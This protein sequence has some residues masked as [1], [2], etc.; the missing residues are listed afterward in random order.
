MSAAKK[1]RRKDLI[2][3]SICAA[4]ISIASV[5]AAYIFTGIVLYGQ[6]SYPYVAAAGSVAVSRRAG[7]MVVAASVSAVIGATIGLLQAD[8]SPNGTTYYGVWTR[9]R[10]SE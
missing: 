10:H 4:L 9:V 2:S 6:D 7:L 5:I 3:E 8:S 1:R